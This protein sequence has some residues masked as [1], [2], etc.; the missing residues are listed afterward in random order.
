MAVAD[1]V[2]HRTPTVSVATVAATQ[3]SLAAGALES[4]E[5]FLGT[6]PDHPVRYHGAERGWEGGDD[7][8]LEDRDAPADGALPHGDAAVAVCGTGDRHVGRAA[9]AV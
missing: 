7:S 2:S 8:E 5:V 4:E 6:R 1:P 9:V 3:G